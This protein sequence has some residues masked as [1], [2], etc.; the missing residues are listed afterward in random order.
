MS[1]DHQIPGTSTAADIA[2]AVFVLL[3]WPGCVAIGWLLGDWDRLVFNASWR[4]MS[5]PLNFRSPALAIIMVSLL[6]YLAGAVSY[7]G[8]P[9]S[10]RR[11]FWMLA[12]SALCGGGL[13]FLTAVATTV[14]LRSV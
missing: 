8:D 12:I 5:Y 13:T 14:V 1:T 9:Q 10:R 7:F 4:S 2:R 6:I 3:G 11:G